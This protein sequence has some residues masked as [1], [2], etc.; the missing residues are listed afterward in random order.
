M[1]STLGEGWPGSAWIARSVIQ[2]RR[3]FGVEC[4]SGTSV[5]EN[6]CSPPNLEITG[7]GHRMRRKRALK[8]GG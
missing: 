7:R 4:Q 1:R 2:V 8:L 6:A 5:M 3:G